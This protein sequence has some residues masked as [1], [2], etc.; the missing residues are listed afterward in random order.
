MIRRK[1]N[2][3][4]YELDAIQSVITLYSNYCRTKLSRSG[5][6][7]IIDISDCI[8]DENRTMDEFC[9]AALIETIQRKGSLYD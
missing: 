6:Y 1:L 9:N 2:R 5:R 8:Y 7:F 3:N 4:I